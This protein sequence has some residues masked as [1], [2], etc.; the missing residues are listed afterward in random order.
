ML[1]RDSLIGL[2]AAL[3]ANIIFGLNVPVTKALMDS[4]MSPM[5]YTALRMLFGATVFW[6]VAMLWNREKVGRKDLLLVMAG[7]LIGYLGTQFMFA[8]SLEYTTPVIFALLIS[9]TP[10]ATLL[11]SAVFLHERISRRKSLGIAL[12]ISGAFIVILEGGDGGSGSN[13]LLGI[14]CVLTCV[15]LYSIY[16]VMTR[17][18]ATKYSP[19]TIA[20][21]MFLVSAL[22]LLPIMP[23]EFS[24]QN[25]F[26][27][28]ITTLAL[29]LLGF[30]LVFST[31]LAFFCM[32]LALKKLEAGT[33]SIFMNLQPLVASTV[34]IT[35]GQDHFTLQKLLAGVLVLGGVYLVTVRKTG[36]APRAAALAKR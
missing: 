26:S 3:T 29:A 32:P 35:V 8:Q 24:H 13:N 28:E 12:S 33:V 11:I 1:P 30:A 14:A 21:W 5:G 22:S 15:L 20:R 27:S 16:L 19:V 17:K 18:V 31:T 23:S 36:A 34:A 6:A 9:L 10:V 4:W 7:G 25:I 2:A